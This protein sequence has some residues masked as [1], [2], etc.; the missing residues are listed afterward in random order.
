MRWF[1]LVA[2]LLISACVLPSREKPLDQQIDEAIRH[3]EQYFNVEYQPAGFGLVPESPGARPNKYWLATDNQLAVYALHAAHQN[4]F[5]TELEKAL[6]RWGKT[7]HGIIEALTGETI[8]WPPYPEQQVVVGPDPAQRTEQQPNVCS[9]PND[10]PKPVIC[11]ESRDEHRPAFQDWQA[12]GDLALYGALNAC[13]QG[14]AEQA[15]E[16]FQEAMHLFKGIGFQDKAYFGDP[17]KFYTT[18]KLA[19]AL[20]VGAVLGEPQNNEV[21]KALLAQRNEA[22]GFT[23]LYD[24]SGAGRGDA[25]TETTAYTLLALATLQ[26][27][28]AQVHDPVCPRH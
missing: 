6:Q 5:A 13:N 16:R 1:L 23:A 9:I 18:Y 11:Q 8:T 10:S 25:N 21:L 24:S 4:T 19:L 12:Y 3:A 26:Q 15:H 27:T 28:H 17:Q 2:I 7:R 14:D 22:G 20:Y